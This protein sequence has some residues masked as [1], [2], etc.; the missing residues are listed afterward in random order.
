MRRKEKLLKN[1]AFSRRVIP[2]LIFGVLYNFFYSG[3]QND[4]L[5][6]ITPYFSALGW[7]DL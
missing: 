3:L 7:S 4:H 1:K 2:I 6:V 5:N